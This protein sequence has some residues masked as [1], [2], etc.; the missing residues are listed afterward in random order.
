MQANTRALIL[1]YP[2]AMKRPVPD[3]GT[4]VIPGFDASVCGKLGL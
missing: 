3:L 1:N 4:R 2:T